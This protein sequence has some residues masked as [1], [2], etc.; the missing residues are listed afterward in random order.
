MSEQTADLN[1]VRRC[2]EGDVS[3]ENAR[4]YTT[5]GV[6]AADDFEYIAERLKGLENFRE[7]TDQCAP[8]RRNKVECNGWCLTQKE[9]HR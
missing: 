5:V 3:D 2:C 8:C 7:P 9:R 4:N 6:R 1:K